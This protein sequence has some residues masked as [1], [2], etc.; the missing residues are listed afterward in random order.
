MEVKTYLRVRPVTSANK[1][2]FDISDDKKTLTI[3]ESALAS[4]GIGKKKSAPADGPPVDSEFK[5]D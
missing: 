4:A 1:E 3:K 5:F 2:L